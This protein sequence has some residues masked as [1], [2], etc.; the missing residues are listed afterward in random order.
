ME[1]LLSDNMLIK[2]DTS[3]NVA[4]ATRSILFQHILALFAE[5]QMLF[6]THMPYCSFVLVSFL[7]Y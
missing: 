2:P 3:N 4:A 1:T 5:V 7:H 6:T